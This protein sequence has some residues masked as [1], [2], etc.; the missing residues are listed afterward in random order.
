MTFKECK[1]ELMRCGPSRPWHQ[2]SWAPAEDYQHRVRGARSWEALREVMRDA[3]W[4]P[5]DVRNTV[6]TRAGG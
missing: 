6:I 2:F 3:A 5:A 1:I 4:T